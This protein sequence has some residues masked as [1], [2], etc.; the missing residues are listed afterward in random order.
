DLVGTQLSVPDPDSG[1][2]TIAFEGARVA[3]AV[4]PVLE[5]AFRVVGVQAPESPWG[6][7]VDPLLVLM[8]LFVLSALG[9]A[10]FTVREAVASARLERREAETQALTD[11]L[12]DA[13]G[14]G[15]RIRIARVVGSRAGQLLNDISSVLVA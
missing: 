3:A 14:H 1:E 12:G 7:M 6:A 15:D 11:V 5:G 8:L 2:I 9:I 13:A 10:R 4:M